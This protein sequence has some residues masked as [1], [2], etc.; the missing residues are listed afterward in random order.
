MK[1]ITGRMGTGKTTILFEELRKSYGDKE[2]CIW[3]TR[4]EVMSEFGSLHNMGITV[5]NATDSNDIVYMLFNN[6]EKSFFID[7]VVKIYPRDIKL[8][9]A[10]AEYSKNN[11][12]IA[13]NSAIFLPD[14][15]NHNFVPEDGYEFILADWTVV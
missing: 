10:I 2:S 15:N 3:V 14:M 8:L 13:C 6:R 1:I 12:T 7:D 9:K 11:I 4:K 5:V